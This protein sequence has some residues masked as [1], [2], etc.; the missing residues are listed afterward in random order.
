MHCDAFGRD[1]DRGF[2]RFLSALSQLR[3]FG[4]TFC[5]AALAK[6][7]LFRFAA[8]DSYWGFYIYTG[9]PYEASLHHV[10]AAISDVDYQILDCGA[11]YGYWSV[12]LSGS[13]YGRRNV[14]AIE[15]SA[16]TFKDCNRIARSMGIV[17]TALIERFQVGLA[18]LCSWSAGAT[19]ARTFAQTA[20]RTLMRGTSKQWDSIDLWTIFARCSNP[21]L[22][23]W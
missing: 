12:I 19:R 22:T 4:D 21:I 23:G 9:T 20:C 13:A 10:F 3:F 1:A 5:E 16:P 15:A 18:N 2:M 6:D 7:S 17:F 8:T 11:N 14:I